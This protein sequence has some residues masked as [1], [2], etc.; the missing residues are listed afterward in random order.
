MYLLSGRLGDVSIFCHTRKVLS[1]RTFFHVHES[2]LLK[3]SDESSNF[4]NDA[5]LTTV[6]L[7]KMA[8]RGGSCIHRLQPKPAIMAFTFGR[9]FF[10]PL[11]R[12]ING[13]VAYR[14]IVI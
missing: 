12:G 14:S 8:S 13:K 11:T 9:N 7:L 1:S 6:A 5:S 3:A 4:I 10:I 2:D